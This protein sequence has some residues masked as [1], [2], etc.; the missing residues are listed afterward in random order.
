M[1]RRR[2]IPKKVE[3]EVLLRSARRCCICYGLKGDFSEKAGQIAHV[4]G[5]AANNQVENLVFLC[6][7][8]HDAYDTRHSQSKGL[9]REEVLL[10][11]DILH[12]DVAKRLPR[13]SKQLDLQEARKDGREF[14]RFLEAL[15]GG[16]VCSGCLLSGYEIWKAKEAGHLIIDPFSCRD[17]TA[18]SYLLSVGEVAYVGKQV[19]HI[20][21]SDALV[22]EAGATALISTREFVSLPIELVG[23]LL[24]RGM[25]ERVGFFYSARAS[26]EPGYRGRLFVHVWNNGKASAVLRPKTVIAAI[27]FVLIYWPPPNSLEELGKS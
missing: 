9:T 17:L 13:L 18:A 26:I 27:E 7:E 19:R 8:H 12:N 16:P 21:D 1:G 11:R 4:D 2:A 25:M 23:R 24:P 6:L 20:S 15:R 5:N 3:V 14:H 22:V 10:Y